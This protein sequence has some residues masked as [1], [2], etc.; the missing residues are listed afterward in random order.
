M[1]WAIISGSGLVIWQQV[2][3]VAVRALPIP[4]RGRTIYATSVMPVTMRGC[5]P[6]R[7]G[8]YDPATC[9][10]EPRWFPVPVRRPSRHHGRHRHPD[11]RGG[12]LLAVRAAV[13]EGHADGR[14]L[15]V[16]LL[17]PAHLHAGGGHRARDRPV[18]AEPAASTRR[19]WRTGC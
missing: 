18:L 2:P 15:P 14:R 13:R 9:C 8:K 19:R 16:L 10:T 1:S 11:H 6:G 4:G 3:I 17:L 7:E 5:L 12:L